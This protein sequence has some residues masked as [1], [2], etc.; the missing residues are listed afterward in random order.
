MKILGI[1]VKIVIVID[2]D[3]FLSVYILDDPEWVELDLIRDVVL[4]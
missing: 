2:D 1:I 3:S 4:A